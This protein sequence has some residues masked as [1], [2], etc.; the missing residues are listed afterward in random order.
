[1]ST[2][3]ELSVEEGIARLNKMLENVDEMKKLRAQGSNIV[4]Q[5]KNSGTDSNQDTRNKGKGKIVLIGI[6]IAWVVAISFNQPLIAIIGMVVG[7]GWY[8]KSSAPNA[9]EKKLNEEYEQRVQAA[10]KEQKEYEKRAQKL[11]IENV[12][13]INLNS[14]ICQNSEGYKMMRMFL[15]SGQATSVE[16]AFY[17]TEKE[18]TQRKQQHDMQKQID[19]LQQDV[20]RAEQKAEDAEYVARAYGHYY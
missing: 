3:R 4:S 8:F 12:G 15:E 6:V 5:A 1:M 13:L 2:V 7:I 17:M 16:M 19:Q 10:L 18:L 9:E 20:Q 11:Y 14:A